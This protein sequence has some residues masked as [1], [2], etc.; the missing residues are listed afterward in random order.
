MT[1]TFRHLLGA[2][3]A[4]GSGPGSLPVPGAALWLAPG[5]QQYT[6]L[7]TALVTADGDHIE[8]WNDQ[9]GNAFNGTQTLDTNP[10][11]PFY[12]PGITNRSK[13]TVE[14]WTG[15][16]GGT[17]TP[18]NL[19]DALGV[20]LAAAGEGEMF[21]VF[22]NKE[23]NSGGAVTKR[24]SWHL[25]TAGSSFLLWEDGKIYESFGT[26]S[27]KDAISP[28]TDLS[29][30]FH[31]Y[32]VWSKT[33]DYGIMLDNASIFTTNVNTVAFNTTNLKFGYDDSGFAGLS[34]YVSE[35]VIFPFKL[36]GAQRT[37]MT[38]HCT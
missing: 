4:P 20:A 29:S 6:D 9:S 32:D 15:G 5:F 33:N 24:G 14:F 3:G 31:V 30:G 38:T 10:H 13:A 17:I 25:G 16:G 36:S 1:Q 23:A 34:A 21:V 22:K 7:G 12:R 19:P 2:V 8:Q 26:N 35:L 28:G 37:L 11:R 27:R 18:L